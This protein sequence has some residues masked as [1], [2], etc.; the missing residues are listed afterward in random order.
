MLYPERR[1][2]IVSH[3]STCT[4]Q[5]ETERD[6]TRGRNGANSVVGNRAGFLKEEERWQLLKRVKSGRIH[7]PPQVMSNTL[8]ITAL[9]MCLLIVRRQSILKCVIHVFSATAKGDILN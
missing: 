7:S 9:C 3:C 6:V 2:E 4:L 1:K 5:G 8:Q